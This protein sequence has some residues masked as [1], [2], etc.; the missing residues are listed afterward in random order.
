M[1]TPTYA[2]DTESYYDE[3][4]S[5]GTLGVRRYV[6]E[7]EHYLVSIAGS[8]GFEWVGDPRSVPWDA[9]EFGDWVSHNAAYDRMVIEQG[10]DLT[11]GPYTWHCSA[12]LA[13]FVQSPRALKKAAGALLKRKV[14]KDVRDKMKGRRFSELPPEQQQEVRTY[15][16]D[17]A[18]ACLA[19]WQQ[20][21]HHQPEDER[22]L[23]RH[24]ASMGHRGMAL[25]VDRVQAGLD[26]LREAS[27]RATRT[28][29]WFGELTPKGK[30]VP[31]TSPKRLRQECV[32]AGIPAPLSTDAKSD[33]FIS[34]AEEWAG[35]APFVAAIQEYRSVKRLLDV[36]E[37][38]ER[39]QID[40]VLPYS[41]KYFGACHTGRWSG[42]GGLNMQNL[43]R[44]EMHGVDVRGCLIPR[45]G[46]R[47]VV[48]DLAQI[49]ARVLLWLV[50]DERT[51]DLL[52][53][54][55]DI[56]EAHARSTMGY[57]DPRPLKEVDPTKR[58]YAKCRVLG[59]GYGLGAV[60]YRA[61]VKQW[62][63]LTI[64][65]VQS[66]S[67]VAGYRS[68]NPRVVAL[69]RRL[70]EELR[71]SEGGNFVLELPTGRT[72][73]YYDIKN[74]RELGVSGIVEL[75]GAPTK[76]YGGKLTENLVQATAREIFANRLRELERR[77]L[78]VALHVHDEVVCEVDEDSAEEAAREVEEVL[79]TAPEWAEGLPLAAEAGVEER[80]GK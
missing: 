6:R 14:S 63:G 67:D 26:V 24:T 41:L 46:K 54:G 65:D 66:E 78:T 42:D 60:K 10:L 33:E 38:M 45:P 44:R 69:W 53:G 79:G 3:D 34:W 57:S 12:D 23:S 61:I 59:L 29:P 32:K 47:L 30:E 76:L 64:D 52:R 37:A 62:A 48:A 71:R 13:A 2:I 35:K 31:L 51:L 73:T 21:E 36:L 25:D 20:F 43:P 56:Y 68:T 28:I 70:G 4:L 39:R 7:T 58:Q 19:I 9:M 77:G 74:R 72:I 5:I 11:V 49:E 18:R 1:S 40:G 27:F 8:D 16:L 75:G 50:G 17:D 22:W 55:M 80:Y 15:A